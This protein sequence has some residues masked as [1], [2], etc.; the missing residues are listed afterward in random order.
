VRCDG[1]RGQLHPSVFC[2]TVFAV[3][4][5]I[6]PSAFKHGIAPESIAH[7][8]THALYADDDFQGTEPP[9]VL[10]LGPDAA[11]NVLEIVGRFEPADVL[12]V[13]MP[14]QQDLPFYDYCNDRR[15]DERDHELPSHKPRRHDVYR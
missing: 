1:L 10:V 8:V 12:T 11:G 9:K 3:E 13:F 5:N 15:P 2:S 6:R 7:A 14:C 4:L